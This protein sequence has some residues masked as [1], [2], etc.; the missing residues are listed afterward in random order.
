M[1]KFAEITILIICIVLF[2]FG[3]FI[4]FW[5]VLIGILSFGMSF[6]MACLMGVYYDVYGDDYGDDYM[7]E[8][9]PESE[10]K[11]EKSNNIVKLPTSCPHCGA[12][13]K[14]D[15]CSYCGSK[16]EIYKVIL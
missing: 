2:I 13:M 11:V 15:T 7:Y 1:N 10:K 6:L 16:S 12:P 5:D 14:N 4:V 8:C 9:T 3:I